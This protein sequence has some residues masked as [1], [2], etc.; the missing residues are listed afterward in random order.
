MPI[1]AKEKTKVERH[2]ASED[3]QGDMMYFT[4]GPFGVW[5]VMKSG[6]RMFAAKPWYALLSMPDAVVTLFAFYAVSILLSFTKSNSSSFAGSPVILSIPVLLL[7][8][9]VYFVFVSAPLSSYYKSRLAGIRYSGTVKS[10]TSSLSVAQPFGYAVALASIALAIEVGIASWLTIV[11]MVLGV[12]F[13]FISINQSMLPHFLADANGNRAN[14]ISRGWLLLS[15]SSLRIIA[16]DILAFSPMILL[17]AA[18]LATSNA[19]VLAGA[20]VL[21]LVSEGIWYG[22]AGAIHEAVVKGRNTYN[23]Y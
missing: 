21:F 9:L 10:I 5:T 4:P 20:F 16:V 8:F 14:A 17:L 6:A 19:Y 1:T 12:V 2:A 7:A 11:V 13:Y 23:I 18:F 22:A 3:V 15:N